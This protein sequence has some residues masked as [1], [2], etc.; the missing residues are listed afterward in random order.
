MTRVKRMPSSRVSPFRKTSAGCAVGQMAY[1]T[2]QRLPR[3][4]TGT[5]K[6]TVN[7][8][9][10]RGGFTTRRPTWWP[11]LEATIVTGVGWRIGSPVS[12]T[13]S[14]PPWQALPES[15]ESPTRRDTGRRTG[16]R[17]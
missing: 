5:V 10:T 4:T 15:P 1:D 16:P 8:R 13:V 11:P 6:G 17:T 9:F 14:V 12:R 3:L 7:G 2:L